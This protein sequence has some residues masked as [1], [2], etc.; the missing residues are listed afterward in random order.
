MERGEASQGPQSLASGEGK[1][2]AQGLSRSHRSRAIST[3]SSCGGAGRGI[4]RALMRAGAGGGGGRPGGGPSGES[5]GAF[6]LSLQRLSLSLRAPGPCP[7]G[8]APASFL[9]TGPIFH[10]QTHF[11]ELAVPCPASRSLYLQVILPAKHFFLLLIGLIHSPP[12]P[13]WPP[14]GHMA[15]PLPCMCLAQYR[16]HL[17]TG[18]PT[19]WELPDTAVPQCLGWGLAFNGA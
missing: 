3:V 16:P 2:F 8:V 10:T 14:R 18:S 17:Q 9:P 19:E 4:P 6:W 7:L 5:S 13:P 12:S 1:L 15:P 11:L